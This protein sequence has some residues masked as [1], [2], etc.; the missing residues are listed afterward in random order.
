MKRIGQAESD[1]C[2]SCLETEETAPHIFAC[3]RRVQWQATFLDSLR[4]LLAK[5]YTQPDLQMILM[6]GIQG[7]LQNDPL[8]DMPTNH[9]EPSFELL[10]SSQNDIGWA[11][12]LRGRFRH[13]WVQMAWKLRNADLHGIDA[14][15]QEAKR[16]AKLKPAIVALY[17]TA[18]KLDYLDKRLF[19]LPLVDRLDQKSHEQ[20]AWINVVTPTVRQAKAEAAD[21]IH[22]TQRDIREFL[23]RPAAQPAAPR[24]RAEHARPAAEQ[25]RPPAEQAHAR[26]PIPRLRDG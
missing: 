19:D 11:H 17:K 2:P 9:R 10:V 26:Q 15:D 5:L 8:F 4:T 1:L 21:K 25:P 24:P 23:I 12:L 6:V 22:K 13:H 20:T 3:E 14:A 18:D 16:K 7:A